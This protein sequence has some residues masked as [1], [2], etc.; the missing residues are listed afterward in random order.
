VVE[1]D[2]AA[3]YGTEAV[4]FTAVTISFRKFFG[5]LKQIGHTSR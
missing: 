1:I 5:E 4:I 3:L 2:F